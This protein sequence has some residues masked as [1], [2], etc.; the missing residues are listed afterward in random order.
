M[1]HGWEKSDLTVVARK[2]AKPTAQAGGEAVEQRVGA[3]GR[4]EQGGTHRTQCR[5][6]VYFQPA[7]STAHVHCAVIT[8]GGS[9]V[10]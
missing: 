1:M 4:A 9:P 10:P 2:P 5:S 6:R 7:P 3:K 8:R